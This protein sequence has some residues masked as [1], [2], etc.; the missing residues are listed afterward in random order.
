MTEADKITLCD[1]GRGSDMEIWGKRVVLREIEEQDEEMLLNLNKMPEAGKVTG[2]YS[3]QVS[4]AHQMDW[5]RSLAECS[6]NVRSVIADRKRREEGLGILVLSDVDL[7]NGTAEIYIK[8]MKSARGKGYGEEA[9]K[10]VV[11]YGFQ[12]LK[13][14]HIYANILESNMAS[15][16]LFEACGFCQESVHLSKAYKDGHYENVC[17][18]GISYE[19]HSL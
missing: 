7:R 3:S 2:G 6:G 8:L 11:S 19:E 9:V 14:K 16:R 12:E 10:A 5:F 4:Y 13:L 17:C 1:F 18:Y 15:R